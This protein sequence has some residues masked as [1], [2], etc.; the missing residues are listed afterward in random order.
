MKLYQFNFTKSYFFKNLAFK[1]VESFCT[2][3]SFIHKA[4]IFFLVNNTCIGK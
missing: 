3:Y 4:S 1:E 2:K